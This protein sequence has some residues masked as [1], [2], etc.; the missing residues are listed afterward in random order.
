MHN[1]DLVLQ[2]LKSRGVPLTDEHGSAISS[3]DVVDRHRE[4]T[5][6]LLWKIALAFQVDISLNLDQLKEEIDFSKAHT[7]YKESY[8]CTNMPFTSYY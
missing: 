2:V 3:K 7:Q 6:G 4:K 5:L 1:V 8:V